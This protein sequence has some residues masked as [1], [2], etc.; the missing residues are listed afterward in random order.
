MIHFS[1]DRHLEESD[2]N[3]NDGDDDDD[4]DDLKVQHL[5]LNT[6]R[7]SLLACLRT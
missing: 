3:I 1:D 5:S 7:G 2:C 6:G 4:D